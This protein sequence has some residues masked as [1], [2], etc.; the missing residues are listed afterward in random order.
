MESSDDEYLSDRDTLQPG[1]VMLGS[2]YT[3]Y[4]SYHTGLF[5]L[6]SDGDS[7]ND[8]PAYDVPRD[9]PIIEPT[10]H[11]RTRIGRRTQFPLPEGEI[12]DRRLGELDQNGVFRPFTPRQA[13]VLDIDLQWERRPGVRNYLAPD[14]DDPTD[15]TYII[16]APE[17]T[18][19]DISTSFAEDLYTLHLNDQRLASRHRSNPSHRDA[20]ARMRQRYED[21]IG[22]FWGGSVSFHTLDT[23]IRNLAM[24]EV[25]GAEALRRPRVRRS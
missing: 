17:R 8:T 10:R 21:G 12:D 23:Q 20:I 5:T 2:R 3:E 24:E 13:G 25:Y 19:E 4:P 7:D 15:I 6:D 22:R 14:Y 16:S 18:V 1:G 9:Y 11:Y